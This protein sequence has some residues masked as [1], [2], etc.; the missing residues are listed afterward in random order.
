MSRWSGYGRAREIALASRIVGAVNGSRTAAQRVKDALLKAARALPQSK[1]QNLAVGL[2]DDLPERQRALVVRSLLRHLDARSTPSTVAG[3]ADDLGPKGREA[4]ARELLAELD[5]DTLDFGAWEAAGLHVTKNHFLSPIPDMGALP[6]DVFTRRSELPGI[7]MRDAEQLA[8]LR[9]LGETYGPEISALPRA[10]RAEG[11]FFLDNGAFSGPDAQMY[12]GLVRLLKPKRIVEI[13]GGWSTLC[14]SLALEANDREGSSGEIVSYEPYPY[15]FLVQAS[16][17]DAR[18]RLEQT[19][20][21]EVPLAAFT[22]LAEGDVLFID[23][24]HVLKIGSDVQYEFLEVLPRVR[25]GVVVHVHDI[26][27]P[28]EYPKQWVADEHRFWN[29]QYLLQA[30]LMFNAAFEV[31]LAG[32]YLHASYPDELSNVFSSYDRVTSLPGSFWMRR[33]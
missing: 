26:F 23:S 11:G 14:A 31:L 17:R 16:K 32:S 8:T 2:I 27:L 28:Y 5:V 21:Q 29:E 13:G 15:D 20:I 33:V 1:R 7:D 10:Q 3:R 25:S 22:E 30:F 4:L 12:Y 9:R 24:S 19:V 6:A 18:I